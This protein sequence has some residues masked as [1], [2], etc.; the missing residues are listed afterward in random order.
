MEKL[1]VR[2][3]RIK[4]NYIKAKHSSGLTILLYPMEGYSSAYALFGTKYGSVDRSFKTQNNDDYIT[5]PD[6]IAHFLEHK[7]FENEDGDAFSL[8]AKTGASANAY[9]SF[10]RTC[11]LFSCT[12]NFK[13]SLEALLSFVRHPYFT[14]ETVQKEQGIIGQE[15]R[16]YRDDPY[17]RS[18]F[19]LL[20]AMYKINPCNI[21]I[22]GTEESISQITPEILFDCY[23]T[24][25]N[26]NNMVLAIS[27]NFD[28]EQ[29][30]KITD[31]I[32]KPDPDMNIERFNYDEP[33]AVVQEKV[34]VNLEVSMPLFTCGYKL[35]PCEGEYA[36]KKELECAIISGC[37]AGEDSMLYRRLYDEG[38][39]NSSFSGEIMF[40]NGYFIL[41]FSGE[42]R[43]PEQVFCEIKK[44]MDNLKT[45]GIDPEDF[46]RI[47][48][49]IYGIMIR[50]FNNVE[51]VAGNLVVSQFN[52]MDICDKIEIAA[53]LNIES[54]NQT[55]SE[56]D[57]KKTSISMVMPN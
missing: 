21:D 2:S 3:N 22:A 56:F 37:I 13:Q 1:I 34:S 9:T 55:L 48:K 49:R 50:E 31:E 46:S 45:N 18:F 11:Y 53:N 38:L 6:G 36:V 5:V 28:T 39:V 8:F 16:M 29:V 43:E 14:A 32:I 41:G 20:G 57:N 10:D 35:K 7:L 44:E 19:G 27:G 30:F 33:E 47:K 25:Y 40:G 15:I 12:D 26:L 52:D 24:F 23:N 54:V 4:E 51:K 42:S 17:W